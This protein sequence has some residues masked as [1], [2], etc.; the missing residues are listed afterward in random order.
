MN[1]DF[2]DMVRALVE[3][4]V[5]FMIVGAYALAAHNIPRSTGDVDIWIRPT[6]TNAGRAWRAL[7]S[8]G[9]PLDALR[10]SVTDLE[11]DDVV[12]QLGLPPRRID[13]MTSIS[14]VDFETAAKTRTYRT[15]DGLEVPFI[16]REALL[17][18]KRSTGRLKD[19]VDAESL[20]RSDE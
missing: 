15:I 6:A 17:Q 10:V 16:G 13:L 8:F 3:E 19:L 18:N 11:R 5:D 9:A 14:G 4:A 20:E 7:E 1:E 12:I 2:L